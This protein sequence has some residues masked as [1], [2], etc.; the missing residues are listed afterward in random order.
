MVNL[1][2]NIRPQKNDGFEATTR[3]LIVEAGAGHLFVLLWNREQ[4]RIDSV[5]GF[6][7]IEDWNIAWPDMLQQ[8][9]LLNFRHVETEIFIN[10]E[11]FLPTP[12]ILYEPT[13]VA[14]Q[15]AILF[16]EI[17]GQYDAGDVHPEEGMVIGWQGNA[18]LIE[19]LSSHFQIVQLRSMASLLLKI[20]RFNGS[21]EVHGNVIVSGGYCWVSIWR[22]DNLL[23]IKAISSRD[24]DNVAYFLLN[25]CKNWGIQP[26]SIHWQIAGFMETDS[27]LWL[28]TERFFPNFKPM[29]R[30]LLGNGFP[31]HFLAHFSKYL[32]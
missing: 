28:A 26:E 13:A 2:Y 11:R 23:L 14:E 29:E 21:A 9:A 20:G 4:E 10:S 18:A 31:A 7:N 30:Q 24:V 32:A 16:G 1:T 17:G 8:S 15:L 22:G 5:E 27:P 25:A 12:S 3:K 19:T 6:T